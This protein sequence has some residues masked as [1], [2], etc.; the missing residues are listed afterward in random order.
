MSHKSSSQ[1]AGHLASTAAKLQDAHER[2]V[3]GP[4]VPGRFG[5]QGLPGDQ[6]TNQFWRNAR[7]VNHGAAA[8]ADE[9]THE[10]LSPRMVN[11]RPRE[12]MTIEGM[13]PSAA[14][15][16]RPAPITST[17]LRDSD[18]DDDDEYGADD[19]SDSDQKEAL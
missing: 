12:S 17:R 4:P 8:R 2:A 6:V 14:L 7:G 9:P 3:D 18:F 10:L 11:P 15:G 19:Y 5:P 16:Q 1:L 13:S